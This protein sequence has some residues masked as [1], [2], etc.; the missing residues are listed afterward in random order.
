MGH[1]RAQKRALQTMVAT[2][3]LAV[4]Q[5]EGPI[6]LA[7]ALADHGEGGTR[8][9]YTA[10]LLKKI[11]SSPLGSEVDDGA[12]AVLHA[13]DGA[14]LLVQL[15]V[16]EPRVALG[17]LE[18]IT[19]EW[20]T[21]GPRRQASAEGIVAVRDGCEREQSTAQESECDPGDGRQGRA[22]QDGTHGRRY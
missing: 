9:V 6:A 4:W 16:S 19:N 15:G 18:K 22:T 2:P 11:A 17:H 14:V 3:L 12:Q 10:T 8:A 21:G 13:E 5:N 1:S 7:D 20:K